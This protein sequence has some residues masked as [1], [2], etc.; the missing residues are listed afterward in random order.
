M[1]EIFFLPYVSQLAA[2][3]LEASVDKHGHAWA[4]AGV[5]RRVQAFAKYT[6]VEVM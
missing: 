5:C 6:H 3:G 1:P 2:S 4:C